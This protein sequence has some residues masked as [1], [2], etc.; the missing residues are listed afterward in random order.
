MRDRFGQLLILVPKIWHNAIS[1]TAD[2]RPLSGAVRE[3]LAT[4]MLAGLNVNTSQSFS[5]IETGEGLF[6]LLS[7]H[8]PIGSSCWL[9][10]GH[11]R[12]GSFQRLAYG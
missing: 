8:Q 10:H 9:S 12:I 3:I 11:I 4:E 2:G 5:V 1:A 7:R 6:V